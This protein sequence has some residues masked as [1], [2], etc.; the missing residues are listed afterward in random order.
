ML[1][2]IVDNIEQCKQETC[3]MLFSST[4]NRLCVYI[5]A[6]THLATR[7]IVVVACNFT[8]IDKTSSALGMAKGIFMRLNINCITIIIILEAITT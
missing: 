6:C 3:S 4:L 8:L 7:F 5:Y 2:N 1:K